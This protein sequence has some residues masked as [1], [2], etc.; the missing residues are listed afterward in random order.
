MNE[1]SP[2]PGPAT[3]PQLPAEIEALRS[4]LHRYCTRMTGSIFDGEDVVQDTLLA[5]QQELGKR[6]ELPPLRPWLFRI[7]HNRAIDHLRRRQRR[8]AAPGEEMDSLPADR[9]AAPDMVAIKHDQVASAFGR[10]LAIPP[11][12]RS[13]V[14]LKEVF[15]YPMEEIAA[16]LEL[17]VPAVKSALLRGRDKLAELG[18]GDAVHPSP[19][20]AAMSSVVIR[21]ADLFNRRDWDGLR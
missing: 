14:I 15:D 20:V 10:L 17:T 21:Y 7:A 9:S 18:A 6:S 16:M 3:R 1:L 13:C 5:A 11:V 8:E 12:Q 2:D 19:P 4:D